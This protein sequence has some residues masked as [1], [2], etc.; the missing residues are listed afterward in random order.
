MHP[1]SLSVDE[2]SHL[3]G[4]IYEG[5]LE[6]LPWQK[7]LNLIRELLHANY[8]TLILRPSTPGDPGLYVNAGNVT[9]EGYVSYATHYYTFDPFVDLPPDQIVTV[10]EI[11]GEARWLTSP[12]YKD[13]LAQHDVF[14]I[15]GVNVRTPD[16]DECRLRICRPRDGA[17]FSEQDKAF[18]RRLLPH[19]KRAVIL[20][21]QLGR[22]ESERKLYAGVVERLMV[23][24]VTLDKNGKVL[25]TN[26]AAD[27]LLREHD[28]LTISNN[29]LEAAY[30]RDNRELRRLI[31]LALSGHKKPDL[32]LV[33]AM[34]VM[35]PS[36]R[37]NLGIVVRSIPM[38][39]W[40][41]GNHGPAAAVFVRDPE[42]RQQAPHEVV[43][44]MFGLTPAEAALAI[45]LAA[46]LSL[47]E[48]S[49]ALNIRR[50]TARAHLRAI[51]SKTGVTR[52][53]ELV[54][55]LL[56]SVAALACKTA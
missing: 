30:P 25:Q 23:G 11:I 43:Q 44:Q 41:D 20:H 27:E 9:T 13:F 15:M 37:S 33:E 12:L 26:Q 3:V 28:G 19:L 24:T 46:G 29:S 34:S 54:R 49:D 1:S 10:H 7:S 21:T 55:I 42:S 4:L 39:E 35:R 14:H 22:T 2:F 36:G 47:D 52:Q 6:A 16:G 18:C 32:S 17:G 38:S 51:F 56:N 50:N 53:T 8:V 40:S 31:N 5:P 48:A 45:Q